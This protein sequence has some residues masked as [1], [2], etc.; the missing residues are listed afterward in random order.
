MGAREFGEWVNRKMSE[1]GIGASRLAARV[2]ELSDGRILDA[3]MIRHIRTGRR[4]S[5]DTALVEALADAL[6]EDRG[7]ACQIAGV[8]PSDLDEG[9]YRRYRSELA[10]TLAKATKGTWTLFPARWRW[11]LGMGRTGLGAAA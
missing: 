11:P 4:R 5:Y 6:G 10:V 1:R 9:G 2:G 8:W 3:T 7:E